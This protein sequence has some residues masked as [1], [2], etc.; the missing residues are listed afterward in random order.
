MPYASNAGV[1]LYYEAMGAGAPVVFVAD[2]GYGA[3]VWSWQ[4][5]AL[6]GEYEVIVFDNRGTGRSDAPPGPYSVTEL[7][8]DLEAVLAAHGAGSV[9]VIGAG[10]GG[11]VALAYALE[12]T[13]VNRLVLLGTAAHGGVMDVRAQLGDPRDTLGAVLS[14]EFIA[15]YPS[16]IDRIVEWR[17]EE[18]ARGDRAGAHA[19]AVES[20]DVR[21]R[22]V[23][24]RLPVFVAHGS[25]DAVV[26]IAAGEALAE[27]LPRS[28]F[29][30]FA[31]GSHLFYVEQASL[32][33]AA[34][35]GY[36]EASP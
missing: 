36:L 35:A 7:A 31:E 34:I 11:M 18:D 14:D 5:P 4:A 17:R 23:D 12:Y 13:R 25:A 32:V 16:D 22:L 19:A 15:A 30:G 9:V 1:A 3:W 21:D 24:V 33:T 8:G 6:A 28:R 29:D 26:P 27:G 10:M 20:F 2:A